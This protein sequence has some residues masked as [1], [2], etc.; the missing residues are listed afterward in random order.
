MRHLWSVICSSSAIDIESN[1]LSIFNIFDRIIVD[2][3]KADFPEGK[4]GGLPMNYHL[5]SKWALEPAEISYQGTQKVELIS[6]QGSTLVSGT[7]TID[8]T[9]NKRF[10]GRFFF[11]GL[12]IQGTGEYQFR[13]SHR[14]DDSDE[15]I[16]VDTVPL[17]VI[18][19][20]IDDPA[21]HE[22]EE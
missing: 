14:P 19:N 4:S 13:I 22:I 16:E 5:V 15:W 21:E 18:V 1:H 6:P 17:T 2:V 9:H 10:S 12:P 3:T 11:N 20:V 8:L 7:G